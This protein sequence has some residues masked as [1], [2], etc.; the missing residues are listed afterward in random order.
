MTDDI[1]FNV[2]THEEVC[3]RH[4]RATSRRRHRRRRLHRQPHGRSAAR[5]AAIAVRV[6]DNLVGGR[7]SNLA[8]HARRSEARV[9]ASA[10]SGARRPATRCSRAPTTSSTSPASA[11]SCRRSSGRSTTCPPTSRAPS[12]C[13]NARARRRRQ[14]VRLRRLVVLLRPGRRR[15]PAKTIRSRPQYPYALSKYQGEQA[16]LHWHQV[17]GLPVELDPHLQR[18][19]PARRAPP[20]PTARCSACSSRRSSPA[21]RSRS[22]ATARSGATS[23]TSPTSPRRSCARRRPS[24]SGKICNL[25]AGNPQTVN[26]LVELLGGDGRPHSEAA[27]RTRLHL[28]RHHARSRASSAGSRWSRSRRASAHDGRTSSSGATRRSGTRSRSPARPR[29]GFE[30]LGRGAPEVMSMTSSTDRYQHKIKTPEELRDAHRAAAARAQGD[31]VPRHLRRRPSR[32]PAPSDVRQEQGRHPG[33]QPDRRRA[34]HQGALPAVRPAGSARD[35][36][37]RV[38]DGRLRH[39]RRQRRRRSRTWRS[40]S[41]TIFAKGYEY[42]A[43]RPA[44]EDAGGDRDRSKATAAR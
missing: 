29:P 35:E 38:R 42:H 37:R 14:E 11:T 8:H 2:R 3:R 26:R 17:Y 30:Y 40:S 1:Y 10:T 16:V 21:S 36:S 13:S 4:E 5:R 25:G 12:T 31:H 44:A 9:R 6:I 22:S 15:R 20:A 24:L 28:G 43:E 41:P 34:H 19:R 39:H 18:L 33:R 32:P 7:E 27:G 23:S